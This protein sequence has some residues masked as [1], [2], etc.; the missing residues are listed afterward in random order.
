MLNAIPP[1]LS[2]P[3]SMAN[4]KCFAFNDHLLEQFICQ[5]DLHPTL[6]K[7]HPNYESLHSYGVIAT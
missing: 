5:L 3:L 6:I 7:S 1:S 2:P 4:Y